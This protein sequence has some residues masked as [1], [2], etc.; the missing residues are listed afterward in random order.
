MLWGKAGESCV[1]DLFNSHIK[2]KSWASTKLPSNQ[3]WRH[4]CKTLSFGLN[5]WSPGFW[6]VIFWEKPDLV[7]TTDI[8]GTTEPQEEK[9]THPITKKCITT[10][11]Q[12]VA[13]EI[14]FSHFIIP[15]GKPDLQWGAQDKKNKYKNVYCTL[16]IHTIRQQNSLLYTVLHVQ[17]EQHYCTGKKE[18]TLLFKRGWHTP[19]QTGL[20]SRGL[21]GDFLLESICNFKVSLVIECNKRS[22]ELGGEACVCHAYFNL[23]MHI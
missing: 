8:K 7:L 11:R 13:Y 12:T 2:K 16:S 9:A 15:D 3:F 18:F 19:Y 6:L 20:L 10:N 22:A 5:Q 21:H 1:Y 4:V 23:S 14:Q 17:M